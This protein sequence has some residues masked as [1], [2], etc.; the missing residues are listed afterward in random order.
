M[1]QFAV[2]FQVYEDGKKRPEYTLNSDIGGEIS[3]ADLVDFFKTTLIVT[4]DT[5]L[6]DEQNMGFPAQDYVTFVDG[7]VN[8][9]FTQVK[10]FG[11]VE[12]ARK[13]DLRDVLLDT[14]NGL[15]TRSPVWTGEYKKHHFVF[16]NGKQVASDLSSLESW[17]NSD[18]DFEDTDKIRFV[19]TQPY[20]RRLERLGVT[21]GRTKTRGSVRKKKG[22]GDFHTV[23]VKFNLPNGAY[24]LTARAIV[25]KYKRNSS[26]R[27]EY[28]SGAGMGLVGQGRSFKFGRR[29][30]NSAGRAYLYPSIIINVRESGII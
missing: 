13:V 18:P 15:L 11:T 20:A 1:I 12:F 5:V 25:S 27:F 30:K 14:Y 23:F 17:L 16:L 22:R 7:K 4:A 19:N 29:G 9:N 28:I 24:A 6:K 8:R 3:L 26:I 21:E 2:D 10:P